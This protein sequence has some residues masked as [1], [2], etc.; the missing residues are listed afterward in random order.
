L[1]GN[2]GILVKRTAAEKLPLPWYDNKFALTGGEDAF[3][4]SKLEKLGVTSARASNSIIYEYYPDTKV[5]LF[6]AMKRD[7]RIGNNTIE[8][9]NIIDGASPTFKREFP[10]TI[11]TIAKW[12]FLLIFSLG[13]KGKT[14]KSLCKISRGLGKISVYFGYHYREYKNVINR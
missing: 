3:V 13:N 8:I 4:F 5:G 11:I 12:S 6:W 7:F 9:G 10:R 2:G 1:T 14:A